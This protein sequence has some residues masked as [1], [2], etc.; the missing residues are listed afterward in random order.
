MDQ[1][2]LAWEQE[3]YKEFDVKRPLQ[4]VIIF[5]A[6]QDVAALYFADVREATHFE[7]QIYARLQRMRQQQKRQATK[8]ILAL[9]QVRSIEF[10]LKATN[11][12]IGFVFRV[13]VHLQKSITKSA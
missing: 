1:S 11:A 7:Q 10:A 6:D 12:A 2:R 8:P 3:I 4:D 5:E 13:R 9:T